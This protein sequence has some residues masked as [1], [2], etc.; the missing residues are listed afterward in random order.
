MYPAGKELL[1]GQGPNPYGGGYAI[2][3]LSIMI[4]TLAAVF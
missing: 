1:L 4:L 3:I 2:V